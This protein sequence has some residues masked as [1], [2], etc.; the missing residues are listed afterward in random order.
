MLG[1]TEAASIRLVM[2]NV[3]GLVTETPV[4][5]FVGLVETMVNDPLPYELVP[6]VKELVKVVTALPS[7]SVKACRP[8][9]CR[10]WRQSAQPSA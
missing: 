1:F 10:P 8:I 2:V 9:R 4:A 3:T 7:M 6:A 5:P